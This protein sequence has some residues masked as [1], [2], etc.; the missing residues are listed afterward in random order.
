MTPFSLL[1]K[2]SDID[3]KSYG[4]SRRAKESRGGCSRKTA[5]LSAQ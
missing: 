4:Q 5:E 2:V 3:L 1:A